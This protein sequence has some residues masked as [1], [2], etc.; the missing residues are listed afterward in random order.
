MV[1]KKF[2]SSK[3]GS[4]YFYCIGIVISI[5][6]YK[7]NYHF[8]NR[9]RMIRKMLLSVFMGI[10]LS[11]KNLIGCTLAVW[12]KLTGICS[13]WY[14]CILMLISSFG[15]TDLMS[16]CQS[17]VWILF[18]FFAQ[19]LNLL[20]ICQA[21]NAFTIELQHDLLVFLRTLSNKYKKAFYCKSDSNEIQLHNHSK[22]IFLLL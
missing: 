22:K 16:V 12:V 11:V 8:L 18:I 6:R 15:K 10:C 14:V 21:I 1:K 9:Y 2:F 7:K 3:V 4:L 13:N 20:Q 19:T 17:L 5:S